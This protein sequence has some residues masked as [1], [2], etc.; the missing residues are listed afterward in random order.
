MKILVIFLILCGFSVGEKLTL[1]EQALALDLSIP[2]PLMTPEF[3][4]FAF[5]VILNN[6]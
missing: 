2:N 3:K 6:S 1:E 5:K 4:W